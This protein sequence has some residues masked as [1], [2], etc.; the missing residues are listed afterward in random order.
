MIATK[1]RADR[2]QAD[3]LDPETGWFHRL[4]CDYSILGI[5]FDACRILAI[6][7][8]AGEPIEDIHG[9]EDNTRSADVLTEEVRMIT[10]DSGR[11]LPM[12]IAGGRKTMGFYAGYAL[13]LNR[14]IQDRP[15]H[16]MVNAHWES[17]LTFFY[18]HPND[19]PSHTAGHLRDGQDG[20]IHL[21][22]LPFVKTHEGLRFE[23][24][25]GHVLFP[26]AVAD[27][28]RSMPL[29]RLA[30]DVSIRTD[31]ADSETLKLRTSQ[32]AFL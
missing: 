13:S 16:V 29:V 30:L 12:S 5:S 11:A 15:S 2:A 14:R 22:E 27:T 10:D 31:D 1:G 9:V 24:L 3:L 17:N 19:R 26:G 6:K 32:F 23:L 21:A 20:P 8:D 4:Y 25:E 28:K 7:G 18:P